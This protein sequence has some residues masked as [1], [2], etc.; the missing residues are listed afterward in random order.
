M[1]TG[2]RSRII[3]QRLATAA[4]SRLECEHHKSARFHGRRRGGSHVQNY[5]PRIRG[6]IRRGSGRRG[7][8]VQ[9]GFGAGLSGTAGDRDRAVGRRRRHGCDRAHRG[10]AAGEGSRPAVQRGQPH[11]R[12]RRG[13]PFRDRDRAA[14]RLHHRHADGR[15]LDDALA[16]AHRTGAE[17]LH[18][19]G[20]D[21]RGSARHPGPF[22][23]A[24]QDREGTGRRHQGRARR[25]VQGLGHRPGRHLA[26]RAGRLDAG[27]GTLPPNQVAWVP[28]NGA[29][30]AMQD[31]AAGGLD[32]TT[33]SVPEARA[34]IEAGKARSLA[35]M[36]P[37]SAI[38][39]SPTCRR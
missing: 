16:G 25:Q 11:R 15:N 7:F 21:E 14:R 35:I 1:P 10:G 6:F 30:P 37:A 2:R 33:C 28:S 34:I 38:P 12:L 8:W 39:S 17:E 24:L 5:A 18:A 22:D 20:A 23:I 19:A 31:L 36:A 9:A 3:A 4:Q 26:S 32:L 29:A 13:R 27:D